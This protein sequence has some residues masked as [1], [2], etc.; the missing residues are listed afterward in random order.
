MTPKEF[1]SAG[2]PV[3]VPDE[4]NLRNHVAEGEDGVVV[5]ANDAGVR[6]GVRRV[7]DTY[8]DPDRIRDT[9]ADWSHEAFREH[10]RRAVARVVAADER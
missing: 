2:K 1:Q 5:P 3:V 6:E 7:L 9:A 4:P 10:A 8:W